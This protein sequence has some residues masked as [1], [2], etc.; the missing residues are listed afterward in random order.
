MS[1]CLDRII[2]IWNIPN[3]TVVAAH[4]NDD[5]ITAGAFSPLG[6]RIIT[7]LAHGQCFIYELE[8]LTLRHLTQILCKNRRG[9]FSKG[10]KITGIE[11]VDEKTFLVTTN[12]SRL[13]LYSLY[14]F[15]LLQKYKGLKNRSNPIRGSSSQCS[16]HIICGS[17]DG[18][19]YIWDRYSKHVS[20]LNPK[21]LR[22]P[23]IKNNSYEYF[24]A[25]SVGKPVSA[26]FAPLNMVNE[27]QRRMR[28]LGS[29]IMVSHVIVAGTTDGTLKVY[30]N[31]FKNVEW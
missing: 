1:G 6:D 27:L 15:E 2:R 18:Y 14:S 12:D 19:V 25:S 17:E 16:M 31:Q 9:I 8:D 13:R 7:G 5:Y 29:D 4:Q 28:D 20:L 3:K 10:R 30:Y 26:V 23:R 24:L 21:S 11:F 22:E